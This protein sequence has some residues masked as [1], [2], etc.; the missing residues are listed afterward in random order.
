MR[1]RTLLLALALAFP[2]SAVNAQAGSV[3]HRVGNRSHA[4]M[5]SAEELSER[6]ERVHRHVERRQARKHKAEHWE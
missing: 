1:K 4:R 5:T 6:N 2:A 3:D